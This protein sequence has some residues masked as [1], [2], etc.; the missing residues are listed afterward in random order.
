MKKSKRII[1]FSVIFFGILFISGC[2]EEISPFVEKQ[3][4]V[5]VTA[6]NSLP[7]QTTAIDSDI[8]AWGDTL[9][10]GMKALA[11]S[12]DLMYLGLVHNRKVRIEGLEGEFVVMDKMN[13]RYKK[14]I[15]IYMGI[16]VQAAREWGRKKRTIFWVVKRDSDYDKRYQYQP[17]SLK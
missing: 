3:M 7:G 5:T 1:F 13:S 15:D 4:E 10:P 6:Y 2:K 16:D 11:V 14:K 8:A 9:E 12:R 17:D